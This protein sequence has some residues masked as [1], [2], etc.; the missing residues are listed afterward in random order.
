MMTIL[1]GWMSGMRLFWVAGVGRGEGGGEG[2][3]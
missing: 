1:T 3:W 2:E